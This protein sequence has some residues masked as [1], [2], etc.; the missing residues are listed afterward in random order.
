MI[1][2]DAHAVVELEYIKVT[3]EAWSEN[4]LVI[5]IARMQ[6]QFNSQTYKA[7]C[8]RCGR[9]SVWLGDGNFVLERAI[10][11][12]KSVP[13]IVVVRQ[14]DLQVGNDTRWLD[15]FS[16]EGRLVAIGLR[17]GLLVIHPK[18][19]IEK[20][21]RIFLLGRSPKTNMCMLSP[22]RTI[23]YEWWSFRWTHE[24]DIGQW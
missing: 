12:G 16:L 24:P 23:S 17:G 14:R 18:S 19:H 7:W 21:R 8:M 1:Q 6:A 9:L 2:L 15:G 5:G 4:M 10:P 3:S 22:K 13:D 11:C 20:I